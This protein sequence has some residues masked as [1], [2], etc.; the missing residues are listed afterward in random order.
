MSTTLY[1]ASDIHGSD[2]LWRKFVNA[3]KFYDAQIL[4]M[5]GDITGKAVIPVV[6][7]GSGYIAREISGERLL[8]PD[9]LPDVERQ[10]RDRGF[11]PARLS[12]HELTQAQEHPEV[13]SALFSEVMERELEAWLDLAKQRLAG[14]AARL[15]LMLGN[16]DM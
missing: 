8:S 14:T 3:A 7:R 12:Q 4:V 13:A 1:Y 16:D 6:A 9:E 2:R 11:Y 15:Y 10:I 5:G